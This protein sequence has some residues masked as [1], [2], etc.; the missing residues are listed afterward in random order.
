LTLPIM[1]IQLSKTFGRVAFMNG[2]L[3]GL[4]F[5][6]VLVLGTF[7]NTWEVCINEWYLASILFT[8]HVKSHPTLNYTYPWSG[9]P[10][11]HDQALRWSSFD[12][13]GGNIV[14]IHKLHF[15]LSI[16][17]CFCNTFSLHQF[18]ITTKENCHFII[19]VCN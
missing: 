6:Y 4:Y 11:N 1:L 5:D 19:I 10:L 9:S 7:K 14:S 15:M 13:H 2:S 18:E 17:W 3:C 8:Y 12:C 16:S